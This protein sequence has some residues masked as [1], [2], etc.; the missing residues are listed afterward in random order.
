VDV[1]PDLSSIGQERNAGTAA[2]ATRILYVDDEDDLRMLV[3]CQLSLEGYVIEVASDGMKALEMLSKASY[4][5]VLLDLHMPGM[6]GAEVMRQL[7]H[8]KL[9]LKVVLLTGDNPAEAGAKC[10]HFG[11]EGFLTKPFHFSDLASAIDHAVA[12]PR[13]AATMP[14]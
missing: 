1:H 14:S 4:D 9:D 5:L 11:A 3:Q 7:H 12:L 10:R 6:D 8:R 13:G 2:M